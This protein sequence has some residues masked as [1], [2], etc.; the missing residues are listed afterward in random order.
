MEIAIVKFFNRHFRILDPSAK[1][2]SSKILLVFF[3]IVLT[4]VV[5]FF[6]GKAGKEILFATLLAL[7]L[8]IIIDEGLL[9][10]VCA[11]RLRP[12][13]AHPGEVVP[14]GKRESDSSFPSSHMSSIT[15]VAVVY[16]YYFPELYPLLATFILFM[17]FSRIHNGMHYLGDV[18]AGTMLGAAYGIFSIYAI[19]Y[20]I[21]R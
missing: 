17:A 19:S 8:H 4:T 1:L 14:I 7:S 15:A 10:H 2:I 16:L 3:G 18:I 5:W 20:L 12:Y 21:A 13:V 11:K 6:G 9:K